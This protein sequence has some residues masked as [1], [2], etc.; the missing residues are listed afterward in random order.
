MSVSV[1]MRFCLYVREKERDP[2]ARRELHIK[3]LF[4]S[5]FFLISSNIHIKT[6]LLETKNKTMIMSQ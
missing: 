4:Y 1:R 5:F 3:K 2:V 6:H